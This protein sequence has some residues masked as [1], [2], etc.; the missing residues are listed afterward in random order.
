MQKHN[1]NMTLLDNTPADLDRRQIH[2]NPLFAGNLCNELRNSPDKVQFSVMK[3]CNNKRLR[4]HADY[5]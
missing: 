1:T 4:M 5:L 2:K 3:I